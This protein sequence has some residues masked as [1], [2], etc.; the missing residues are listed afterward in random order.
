MR[1]QN[2]FILPAFT[3]LRARASGLPSPAR[4]Q[5]PNGHTAQP[6]TRCIRRLCSSTPGPW[7]SSCLM[8]A[9]ASCHRKTINPGHDASSAV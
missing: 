9:R 5:G 7:T 1:D 3:A 6:P 4:T 8:R 2:S